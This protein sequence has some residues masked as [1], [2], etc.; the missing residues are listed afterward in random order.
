MTTT[1]SPPPPSSPPPP[2]PP[3]AT[4]TSTSIALPPVLQR[5][6][7]CCAL[8]SLQCCVTVLGNISR[9]T[10]F[11]RSYH[12]SS[13]STL[14]LLL[15]VTTA[16]ALTAATQQLAALA[17]S[18]STAGAYYAATPAALGVGLFVLALCSLAA[19]AMLARATSVAIYMWLEIAAQ[20]LASQFWDL[21]AKAFDVS[22]SKKFFGFITFGTTFGT[23]L[24]SLVVLPALQA[25]DLPTEFN[26]FIAAALLVLIAA[27]LLVSAD[28]LVPPPSS[29]T[30]T[31]ISGSAKKDTATRDSTA[32]L[33]ADIQT[34][35]YLKHICFFDMLA[36]VIQLAGESC[37]SVLMMI[38]SLAWAMDAMAARKS[39]AAEFYASLKQGYLDLSSPLVDFTPDQ[40]ALIENEIREHFGERSGVDILLDTMSCEERHIELSCL[41]LQYYLHVAEDHASCVTTSMAIRFRDSV[42]PHLVQNELAREL[43]V[44][45][46]HSP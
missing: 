2:P 28:R 33:I 14:T 23:L 16:Y 25:R 45:V 26:L 3:S 5:V 6:V 18:V 43:L 34:R 46:Y 9:D 15:S 37:M 13:L 38:V 22:E 39:Y 36:T 41:A 20:L 44:E 40:L 12:A 4:P 19:P 21:C 11:L 31:P 17:V 7:F 1:P 29:S 32:N 35:T 24:A 42:L 8:F 30:P 27:V 10:L